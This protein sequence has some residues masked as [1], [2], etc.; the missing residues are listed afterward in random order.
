M[1]HVTNLPD[2]QTMNFPN[3]YFLERY[4]PPASSIW[5]G[6]QVDPDA[7]HQ[8]WY[9]AVQCWTAGKEA[10]PTL[11]PGQGG[12]ALL[13]YAVDEGVR[14]NQGR[15]G[16]AEGPAAIRNQLGRLAW[17]FSPQ[18]SVLDVGDIGCADGDLAATQA[19]LSEVVAALL[20]AGYFPLVL[21]G[22]HDVAYG[23]GRGVRQYCAQAQPETRLGI[24][25]FD[26]HFDLRQPVEG[27]N[28]GTP[29]YQLAAEADTPDKFRYC[30]VGIQAAANPPELFATAEA[31]KVEVISAQA[32]NLL[33]WSELRDPLLRF[34]K[35]C[36]H[37]YL[38]IDLDGF[39]SAYAPGVSAPSPLGFAPDILGELL[40]ALFATGKVVSMDIA[41]L[42]PRYDLDDR[43]ARLAARLVYAAVEAQR[44]W[45]GGGG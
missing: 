39:S 3:A 30:V 24:V 43:T 9:Q 45:L 44:L 19:A 20:A 17:H 11:P 15:T 34:A 4:T 28:S 18:L 29:F 31:W 25:N 2:Y 38:T 13:G 26:A 14:R 36:D 6:R 5:R 33:N 40:A 21:G 16:A 41:E 22:G 42:N 35:T 10:L 1:I 12:V 37:L 23:H 27:P 32:V 8:Y 7:G